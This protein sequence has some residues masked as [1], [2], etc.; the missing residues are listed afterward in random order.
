MSGANEDRFSHLPR[1]PSDRSPEPARGRGDV[2]VLIWL[3]V[4]GVLVAGLLCPRG[5]VPAYDE[6]LRRLPGLIVW[7]GAVLVV[8]GWALVGLSLL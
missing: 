3:A 4:A 1:Y 6:M 2:A 8:G 7:F 5:V